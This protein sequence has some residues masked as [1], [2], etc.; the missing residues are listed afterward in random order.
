MKR[1]LV[2]SVIAFVIAIWSWPTFGEDSIGAAEVKNPYYSDRAAPPWKLWFRDGSPVTYSPKR[3]GRAPQDEKD[4]DR[5]LC[6]PPLTERLYPDLSQ[7]P[8]GL[9]LASAFGKFEAEPEVAGWWDDAVASLDENHVRLRDEY[10]FGNQRI[11][12]KGQMIR[13]LYG[14]PRFEDRMRLGINF[15]WQSH[16]R[17][18]HHLFLEDQTVHRM[19][20]TFTFANC[21]YASPGWLSRTDVMPDRIVDSYDG[22]FGHYYNSLGQSG[23]EVHAVAK[24]I[25]AAA[26]LPRETKNLL[27]TH[28]VYPL[29]MLTVFKATLPYRDGTGQEVPYENE[30]RHRPSYASHGNSVSPRYVSR[31]LEYH[32]YDEGIHVRRMVKMAA[33]MII[34]PPVTLLRLNENKGATVQSSSYTS[35][36][37]HA[38]TG[39]RVEVTVDLSD[40][41]DLT[42]RSL[43]FHAH[44]VYPGQSNLEVKIDSVGKAKLVATYDEKYPRGRFPVILWVENGTECPGNPVFVNIHWPAP[45]QPAKPPYFAPYKTPYMSEEDIKKFTG[46]GGVNDPNVQV[47][48]NDKPVIQ[49]TVDDPIVKAPVGTPVSFQLAGR[50]PEGFQ[51]RFYQWSGDVGTI[52]DG[53]FAYTPTKSD[54]GKTLPVRFICSDGTGAY[55]GQ[56]VRIR[57][58]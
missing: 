43:T 35:V 25:Y 2:V 29:A 32:L 27:K 53:Q 55:R 19:E 47:N 23:S 8:D 54:R 3:P 49:M 45:D 18:G 15:V 6:P 20:E 39:E 52:T 48:R 14:S 56:T 40:S 36:R 57:V 5:S 1:L 41:Y 30:L 31:D 46:R 9:E 16:A 21:L 33:N 28:G 13:V 7:D 10:R 37:L 44:R 38:K 17:K 58:E 50:D 24:M 42:N 26:H 51:T 22:L 11:P 12:F 4:G 34:P